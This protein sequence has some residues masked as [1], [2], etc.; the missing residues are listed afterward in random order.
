M[1]YGTPETYAVD[2]DAPADLDAA[3]L[4]SEAGED[5]LGHRSASGK[6]FVLLV[7]VTKAARHLLRHQ[8]H[9]V[10]PNRPCGIERAWYGVKADGHA[11]KVL[12]AIGAGV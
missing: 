9:D 5:R 10:V 2:R 3:R 6:R 1:G 11:S 7:A 4:I 8:R 12:D